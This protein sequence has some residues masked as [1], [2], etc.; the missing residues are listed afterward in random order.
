MRKLRL[1]VAVLA[2]AGFAMPVTAAA[3]WPERPVH[4]IVPFPAGGATDVAAR[5]IANFVSGRLGRQVVVEN[6]SGANGTLGIEYAAK[7]APDGYT[8]LVAT[9]DLSGNPHVYKMTVD[10]L[11]AL[12][13]VVQISRQPI[14]LAAHPL[15]GVGTLSELTALAK[16]QPEVPFGTGSGVGSSQAMVA[17]WYAKLA[18]VTLKQVPYRG[19]APAINDLIAGHVKL[20]SLGSTPLIPHYQAGTLKLLVQST[21][22]RAP[23]LPKVPTFGEEGYGELVLD[24]WVGVFV[25]AGAPEAIAA[26]LN[27]EVNAVLREEGARK[28]LADQAQEP[29]GGTAE[30]FSGF[31][32][33]EWGKYGRLVK[34]LN[35]T[36]E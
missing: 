20:G 32:H 18:G 12:T 28:A 26:R 5:V 10:P 21:A 1:I 22:A 17:L 25:P 27:A 30:A 9:Q 4:F 33:G 3:E 11:T 19:G 15:L 2:A 24:Q 13:P 16:R 6:R 31:V 34:D 29:V 7:S 14:V 36:I 8:V 23:S 35:V